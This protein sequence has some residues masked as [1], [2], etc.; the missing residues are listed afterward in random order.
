MTA[1]RMTSA[2]RVRRRSASNRVSRTIVGTSAQAAHPAAPLG[3]V[4]QPEEPLLERCP[5]RLDRVDPSAGRDDRGDELRDP[6]GGD[7]P[8]REPVA[9]VGQRAEAG[10]TGP[11]RRVEPGRVDPDRV[12]AEELLERAGRDDPSGIDD[13]DPVAHELDLGQEVRVQEDG[14]AAIACGADDPPDVGPAHRIER[15]RRFVEHDEL[16]LAEQGD[17]EAESLLHALRE[18]PDEVVGSVGQP[19]R[20]ERGRDLGRRAPAARSPASAQWSAATSRARSHGW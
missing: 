15:R 9:V 10:E 4:D 16:R 14:R 1:V 7:R 3:L 19:D 5:A 8:D 11:C 13:R 6:V 2:H 12:L 20:I 18:R 17:A